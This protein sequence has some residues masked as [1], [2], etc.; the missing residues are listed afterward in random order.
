M[1]ASE[2]RVVYLPKMETRP[3]FKHSY[4]SKPDL[5]VVTVDPAK[6]RADVKAANRRERISGR[7]T[8]EASEE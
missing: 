1:A 3:G 4:Q 8:A 2:Q 5:K 6:E 7:R